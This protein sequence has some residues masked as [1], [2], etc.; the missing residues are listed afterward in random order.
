MKTPATFRLL[1]ISWAIV[2]LGSTLPGSAGATNSFTRADIEIGNNPSSV[3]AA[4]LNR[5][6]NLDLV[7]T[8][9]D[10]PSVDGFVSV[11]L[12]HGDGT[13][14][15]RSNFACGPQSISVA[16]GDV[17]GDGIPDLLVANITGPA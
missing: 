2:T 7:V 1:C 3:A 15:P 8:G 11:L 4:D 14:G 12:G 13:F 16:A 17:N 5:D 6:G 10:D 9:F